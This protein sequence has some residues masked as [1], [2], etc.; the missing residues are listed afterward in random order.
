MHHFQGD[1]YLCNHSKKKFSGY[2]C[3]CKIEST[4][5]DCQIDLID[6]L[7]L[8]P[9]SRAEVQIS[10]LSINLVAPILKIGQTYQLYEGRQYFGEIFI[11]EDP[12]IELEK[13]VHEGEVKDAIV[14]SIDWTQA[15]VR[16]EG[17]IRE[18]LSSESAGLKPWEEIRLKLEVGD[19]V[20]ICV[21]S[22]DMASRKLCLS[23]VDRVCEDIT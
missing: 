17:G 1:I 22:I 10:F 21:R 9:G 14:E 11:R 20:R 15:K 5:F 7:E 13:W 19:H 12:W 6:R 4:Y 23:L 3:L 2:R 16:L 18:S 8:S